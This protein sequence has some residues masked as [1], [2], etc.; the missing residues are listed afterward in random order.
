MKSNNS[1]YPGRDKV[2]A[3]AKEVAEIHASQ[4]RYLALRHLM[5][6]AKPLLDNPS[7]E[8]RMD[9]RRKAFVPVT[10]NNASYQDK[11]FESVDYEQYELTADLPMFRGPPVPREALE[12][13]EYFCVMG[14]AQTMGRL[15][16]RPWPHLL[17]EKLGLP[18]L[19][20]SYGGAG[21]E[22]FLDPRLLKLAS[23]AK[24]VVLQAMSGRS[25]GCDEYPGGA[26]IVRDGKKTNVHRADV[27]R[28]MWDKDPAVAVEYVRR[29]NANYIQYYK[30]ISRLIDAPTLLIWISDRR[31][32]EWS[33]K[34]LFQRFNW[35]NFPQ[36]IG[37]RVYNKVSGFFPQH[38]EYVYE[39]V[40]EKPISLTTNM[41]CPYFG[42]SGKSFH[43]SFHYY[44]SSANHMALY[45]FLLPWTEKT[46]SPASA[47][48]TLEF[49]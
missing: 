47:P 37:K 34:K 4:G 22:F 26:M 29:W 18:V 30:Q 31:P 20:L 35:G 14:A 10:S 28:S 23:N 19:N 48:A 11:D 3:L 46:L 27:L 32:D 16:R 24:F 49:A 43:E 7:N 21:P 44:P 36:L 42:D 1:A 9:L 39:P 38:L 5:A 13:G 41:E 15:V 12:R 2:N 6:A 40:A 8:L 45:E 33:P 25:V 17:S